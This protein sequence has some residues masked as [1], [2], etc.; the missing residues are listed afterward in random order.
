MREY[1]ATNRIQ[2]Q[3]EKII[4]GPG[5]SFSYKT[6]TKKYF[7]MPLHHHPEIEVI[8]ITAGHGKRFVSN[9]VDDFAPGDLVLIG[10]NVPHFHLC[11]KIYY[12]DNDLFCS[13]RVIQFTRDIFPE[14][15]EQ[16][17]EYANIANLLQRG[18]YG[19]KF[20]NLPS[21]E[22]TA[23][24]MESLDKLSGIKRINAL[25]RMLDLLGRLKDYKILSQ[26]DYKHD[27]VKQDDQ[28]SISSKVYNYLMKNFKRKVSLEEVAT[29]VNQNP[30]SLCRYFKQNTKKS[31]FESL[32]EIRVEYAC[33]LLANSDFTIAQIAYESGYNN[34]SNFNKQF[35]K[36]LGKSPKD[37]KESSRK[38]DIT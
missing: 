3:Y 10:D 11:D 31:I 14:R 7:P 27:T 24:I 25:L 38:T 32:N 21:I 29:H 9:S 26:Y 19:V 4:Y 15:F 12:Q 5:N 1:F 35:K 8:L 6:I 22:Q 2:M 28:N 23:H 37:Y 18:M 16:L 30:T 13:S 17:T 36:V 20:M 34:L 33:K